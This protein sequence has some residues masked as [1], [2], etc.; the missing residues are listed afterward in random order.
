M[1]HTS[2]VY[3]LHIEDVIYTG[4]LAEKGNVSRF[5]HAPY[6]FRDGSVCFLID[7]KIK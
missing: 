4:I 5:D 2:E 6:H 1:K 3:A 7:F